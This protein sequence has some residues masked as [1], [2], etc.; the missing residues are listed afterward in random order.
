MTPSERRAK[1]VKR[2]ITNKFAASS[3]DSTDEGSARDANKKRKTDHA[4]EAQCSHRKM[5]EKAMDTMDCVKD[6]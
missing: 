4:K 6:M 1:A 2:K 5:C 3:L